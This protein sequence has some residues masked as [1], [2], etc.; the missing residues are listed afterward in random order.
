MVAARLHPSVIVMDI[1]VP[2]MNGIEAV[3]RISGQ[4]LQPA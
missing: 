2:K 1:N 3:A 4:A